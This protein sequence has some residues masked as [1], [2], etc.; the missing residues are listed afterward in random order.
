M[1]VSGRQGADGPTIAEFTAYTE[2]ALTN[3]L[4]MFHSAPPSIH[5]KFIPCFMSA[6]TPL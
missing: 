5:T 6:D 3:Y 4:V 1:T 2:A